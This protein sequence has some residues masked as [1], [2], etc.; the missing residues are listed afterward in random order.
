MYLQNS[1]ITQ[2]RSNRNDT[3]TYM[4]A[5]SSQSLF[6]HLAF[7]V[8]GRICCASLQNK[9][10]VTVKWSHGDFMFVFLKCIFIL[11]VIFYS[12]IL[13]VSRYFHSQALG[14][15]TKYMC[16]SKLLRSSNTSNINTLL[17]RTKSELS[18]WWYNILPTSKS[19]LLSITP[20]LY[21]HYGRIPWK[22]IWH[23]PYYTDPK[24][25]SQL[26]F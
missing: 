12:K 20:R 22:G 26:S 17:V 14:C 4:L 23:P 8:N 9:W 16:D 19:M 6:D 24:V 2:C 18:G 3:F 21:P 7:W 25:M 1:D 13:V 5:F 11:F 15:C 10:H